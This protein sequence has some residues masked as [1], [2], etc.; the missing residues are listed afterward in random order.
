MTTHTIDNILIERLWRLMKYE[1]VYLNLANDGVQLYKGIF[2]W[3]KEYNT[4]RRH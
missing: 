3:F 4:E 1:H 2:E